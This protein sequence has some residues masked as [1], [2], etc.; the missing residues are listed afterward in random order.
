MVVRQAWSGWRNGEFGVLLAAL[1]VAVLALAG[2]GSIAQRTTDALAE[3]SRRLVGGDAAFSSDDGDITPALRDAERLRLRAYRSVELASMVSSTRAAPELGTLK[4]LTTDAPLLGAYTVRTT[5]GVQHLAQPMAGTVWLSASGAERMQTPLGG[6]IDVGGRTLALAGIVLEEPDRPINGVELGPRVILPLADVQAAG[7][8][9][10]GARASWRVAVAGAPAAVAQWVRDREAQR[11]PGARVETGDDLSPQLRSALERAQRFLSVS[12]VLTAALAAVAIGMAA[13]QHAERHRQLAAILRS[14]GARQRVIVGV[15]VG[16]LLVLGL[17]AIVLALLAAWGL[18]A[19]AGQW[20]AR[21]LGTALPGARVWPLLKGALVGLWILLT[22]ALPPLLALRRI[23]AL[24][25]LRSDLRT[26]SPPALLLFALALTGMLALFWQAAGNATTAAILLGGLLATA[27]LL[28]VAG[29]GLAALVAR[30]GRAGS[31]IVRYALRNLSRRRRLT[32]AQVVALGI[33]L[34]ALLLLLVRT[35]VWEQWQATVRGDAPNRFVINVQPD[36]RAS[37][38]AVLARLGV[39]SVGFAPLIRARYVG[40]SAQQRGRPAP[41]GRGARLLDREFN[42]ST[43]AALPTGNT[44][45]AGT[46]WNPRTARGQFSVETRFA[47]QLHWQLGDRLAFEVGGQRIEGTLT[48]LRDVRWESFTPNFFV[49]A[50]PDLAR[51][52]PATYITAVK[53]PVGDTRL[54]TALSQALPNANVIDIDAISAEIRRIGDQAALVI[55]VVFWFAFLAGCL[56]FVAAVAATR[57]ERTVELGVLRTLGASSAQL[58][59][60][61]LVEF[62]AIGA[63]AGSIAALAAAGIGTLFAQRVLDLPPTWSATT[64]LVGAVAGTAAAMLAGW[65]SMRRHLA[66][67]VRDTFGAVG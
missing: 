66:A 32:I 35:D 24:A 49:L 33:S 39:H 16:Q 42:L 36:Q 7:L 65:L 62:G 43:A 45:A 3:Q 52:L 28:G 1:L 2:V 56:V 46:F 15:Y 61:Q 51:D 13:R 34:M 31:G 58:R 9:A 63:I 29:A 55:Q 4:A 38:D 48:S 53:V 8:L 27:A 25:V 19:L 60:A 10:P 21:E 5:A 26:P 40:P 50:S 23:S 44:L 6:A 64:L 54:A 14:L 11:T 37:F 12:L 57:R 67:S 47:E 30:I 20:I 59:N 41:Q 17:L 22:F 18:Q